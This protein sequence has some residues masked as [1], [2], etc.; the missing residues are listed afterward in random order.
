MNNPAPIAPRRSGCIAS[1][2]GHGR[3]GLAHRERRGAAFVEFAA[4]APFFVLLV[5]TTAEMN[6][7]IQRVH[8]VSAALREAG[9][10]ASM[11]WDETLPGAQT[12]RQKVEEDFKN[13]LAAG[14]TPRD[15]IEFSM[16]HAEGDSAGEPFDLGDA[17]NPLKLFTMEAS[18]PTPGG[19]FARL[20][21][22]NRLSATFTFRAGRDTHSL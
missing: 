21:F 8:R 10:L 2:C 15:S 5:V 20:W 13:F 18:V 1:R 9:R 22:G 12:P 6:A 4:I 11:D 16:V 7:C 19:S 17:E 3:R 14:G